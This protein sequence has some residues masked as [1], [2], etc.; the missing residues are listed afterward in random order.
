MEIDDDQTV[1]ATSSITEELSMF[2][3]EIEARDH[4]TVPAVVAGDEVINDADSI[5]DDVSQNSQSSPPDSPTPAQTKK[6]KKV[7]LYITR[8]D[9]H[10]IIH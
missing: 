5:P 1:S 9:H 7:Q 6:R 4:V 3:S 2:Y 10:L 8:S